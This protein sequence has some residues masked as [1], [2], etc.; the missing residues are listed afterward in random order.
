MNSW[1][2]EI[3][4]LSE[5][6]K[7]IAEEL[8]PELIHTRPNPNQ[9]SFTEI[10]AH[11][12]VI[13]ESYYPTFKALKNGTYKS[14]LLSK[15]GFM[16]RLI[17]KE[18]LKSVQP[19]TKKKIKTFPVWE[20]ERL[21]ETPDI[22]NRFLLHQAELIKEFEACASLLPQNPVLY[23]PASKM[24]FY[25]LGTAFAIILSHEKR[26]LLQAERLSEQLVSHVKV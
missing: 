4:S 6:Y 12:V 10:L 7:K 14:P 16:V 19:Q 13:N 17:G 2:Q 3:K 1:K 24:I 23:S 20:P 11:L 21:V 8:G 22:L 5:S 26:H 25:H 18:V 15:L 9:W